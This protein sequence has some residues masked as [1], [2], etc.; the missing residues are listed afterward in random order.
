[1]SEL[2]VRRLAAGL[3]R[4]HVVGRAHDMPGL[5]Q[6]RAARKVGNAQVGDNGAVLAVE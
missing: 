2:A 4:R 5:R 1:M 6:A 3:F